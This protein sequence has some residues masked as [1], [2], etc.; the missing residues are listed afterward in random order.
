MYSIKICVCVFFIGVDEFF[1]LVTVIGVDEFFYLVTV[2]TYH[3]N[4]NS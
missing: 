1:Y 3:L 2:V 4:W